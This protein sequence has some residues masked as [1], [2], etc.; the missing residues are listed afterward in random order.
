[1]SLTT[2]GDLAQ[3]FM[4][5]R[6]TA[7]LKSSVQTLS[8]EM[9]TGLATDTAKKTHGDFAPLNAIDSSLARLSAYGAAT[10]ESGLFAQAMQ[11]ALATVE[12][13]AT[14]LGPTLLTVANTGNAASV[15]NLGKDASQKFH[16]AVSAFNTRVGDRA[17]FAGQATD[18]PALAPADT[19]LAALDTVIA[20]AVSAADIETAMTTWF[21]DPA[22]FA[23][24]AYGGGAALAPL[25]I[26][27]GEQAEIGITVM[28]PA[29]RDTLKGLA[30]A[31]MLDRGA[32]AGSASGR[33]DLARRAGESL[34]TSQTDRAHLAAG[35]GIVE[36]QI[37]QAS[38]RNGAETTALN[39]ARLGIVSVD[40][41]ETASKLEQTQTQ[42][43]TLYSITAR[44]SRL[45]L[46]DFL[47]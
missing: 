46:M 26:A 23:A 13:M 19:I 12:G 14:E 38:A 10:S 35:L 34:M 36:G 39:I 24:V 37:E 9:V 2:I 47:R 18:A 17:L 44:L 21:N 30:M 22:G 7:G 11:T 1:M 15:T 43:E 25:P 16:T 45:S 6:H 41:Y 28:D 27:A 33:A 42:L 5:R 20:G 3:S 8:N 4:L 40:P 31:A 29:I 32:L